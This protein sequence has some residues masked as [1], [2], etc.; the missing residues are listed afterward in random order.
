MVENK[1]SFNIFSFKHRILLQFEDAQLQGKIN[2]PELNHMSHIDL[3][4]RLTP[5]DEVTVVSTA[6]LSK[7]NIHAGCPIWIFKQNYF[8]RITRQRK[9]LHTK[10]VRFKGGHKSLTL[11]LT[12]IFNVIGRST[13]VISMLVVW[14]IRTGLE[15]V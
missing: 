6:F 10:V 15:Q 14:I 9:K 1:K 7:L 8:V 5:Q 3:Y 12:S 13:C 2:A 11:I 4:H